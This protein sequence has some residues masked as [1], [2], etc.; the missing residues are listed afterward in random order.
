MNR[1]AEGDECT[2]SWL[3]PPSP[4]RIRKYVAFR[5]RPDC[6]GRRSHRGSADCELCRGRTDNH[7]R[8]RPSQETPC[9]RRSA[10]RCAPGMVAA[11]GA[12]PG[13][14]GR[15]IVPPS[16]RGPREVGCGAPRYAPV[17]QCEDRWGGIGLARDAG[18]RKFGL[19]GPGVPP[20]TSTEGHHV[21]VRDGDYDWVRDAR[22]SLQFDLDRRDMHH[23]LLI[24]RSK[25]T[26]K[27]S[28]SCKGL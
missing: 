2:S 1:P 8:E 25:W 9:C 27:C 11:W 18:Y 5:R 6:L 21:R 24:H 7:Q 10:G 12:L 20:R 19:F 14:R 17:G 13:I 16:S 3:S 26:M 15:H 28:A 23:F 4:G 22:V